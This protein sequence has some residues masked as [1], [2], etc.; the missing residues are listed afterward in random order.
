MARK[1]D[2]L[3]MELFAYVEVYR[4]FLLSIEG[5]PQCNFENIQ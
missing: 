4:K 1:G 3:Q 2:Y 5:K